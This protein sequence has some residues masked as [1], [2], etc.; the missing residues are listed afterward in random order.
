MY[1]IHWLKGL[2]LSTH[3]KKILIGVQIYLPIYNN[4]NT[5]V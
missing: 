1:K 5:N 2:A 3:A 4:N